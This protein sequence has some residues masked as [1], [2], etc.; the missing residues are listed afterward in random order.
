MSRCRSAL[1]IADQQLMDRTRLSFSSRAYDAFLQA[2]EEPPK[3]L[4]R[5]CRVLSELSVLEQ[6][7]P[8]ITAKEAERPNS[9]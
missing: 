5:M 3:E 2:L 1:I 7:D 8:D 6:Q 4:P 9:T